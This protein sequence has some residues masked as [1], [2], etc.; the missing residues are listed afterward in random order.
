MKI[1]PNRPRRA[2]RTGRPR[3]ILV[4]AGI[5]IG[6]GAARTQ[7]AAPLAPP[8]PPATIERTKAPVPE[9]AAQKEAE[10]LVRE[11]FRDDYAKRAP[12]DVQALAVKLLQQ[13]RETK[14]DPAGQFVLFQQA[15]EL[16]AQAG[17][18]ATALAAAEETEKAYAVDGLAMKAQTL[19]AA[20]PP[21]LVETSGPLAESCLAL[22][23]DALAS[24]RLDLAADLAG[25][26]ES[27][28]RET[29][30]AGLLKEAQ[31][32]RRDVEAARQAWPM[33]QA[34][35]MIL[36]SAPDDPAANATA[37]RYAVLI[38]GDWPGG[39]AKL[40]KGADPTL[41]AAAALDLAQPADPSGQAAAGDAWWDAAEKESVPAWKR[42]LR[43]RA[44]HW[45]DL[46]QPSLTG[47][48]KVKVEKRL[49]RSGE[50]DG[51]PPATAGLVGHWPL[52][53]AVAPVKDLSPRQNHGTSHGGVAPAPGV[54]GRALSFDGTGG[55]VS[56]GTAGFPALEAPKTIAFWFRVAA[57]PAGAQNMFGWRGQASEHAVQIGF[58][59]GRLVA[60]KYGGAI[61]VDG[62]VPAVAAWH[63]VAYTFDGKTHVLYVDGKKAQTGTEPPQT[64]R[65]AKADLG[66]LPDLGEHYAGLL[67]KVR[68]YARALA[69]SE[70]SGL[71]RARR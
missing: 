24:N 23:G 46:A 13:G 32:R 3:A 2:P 53:G 30:D 6:A 42:A 28:A 18:F 62:G 70:V 14:G 36:A 56:L 37:G 48:S 8:A 67:D 16:A 17:D 38:R 39:T 49:D 65:V 22:I 52:E 50:A 61:L 12:A 1:R 43:E 19:S 54:S 34:A 7:E 9:A 35:E 21:R 27:A 64:G 63:H 51:A 59:N 20:R 11:L 71:F 66:R 25:K 68:V 26:A 15:R 45:Y 10:R 58:R 69:E 31:R 55:Y 57:A 33:A 4:L 60:W 5:G 41:R 40:A 29:K 47:L 44:R